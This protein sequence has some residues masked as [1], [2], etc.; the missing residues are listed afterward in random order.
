MHLGYNLGGKVSSSEVLGSIGIGFLVPMAPNG[1]R[2]VRFEKR[3]LQNVCTF[4]SVQEPGHLKDLRRW[5]W[6]RSFSLICK[7]KTYAWRIPMYPSALLSQG[8][9]LPVPMISHPFRSGSLGSKR[10][11]GGLV[12]EIWL[13]KK[14]PYI[15]W[16]APCYKY[17]G[18]FH[19]YERP[20]IHG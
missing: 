18:F 10:T 11:C 13:Q 9:H 8:S 12:K 16:W 3:N 17:V 14:W 7:S 19:P 6:R 2:S 4:L 5:L 15:I 20:K 1:E